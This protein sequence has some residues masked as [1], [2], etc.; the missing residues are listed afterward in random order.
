M[1]PPLRY[2]PPQT[3]EEEILDATIFHLALPTNL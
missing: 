2:N 3:H 1:K